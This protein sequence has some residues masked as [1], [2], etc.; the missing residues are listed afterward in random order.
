M[1]PETIPEQ[2][3]PEMARPIMKQLDAGATPESS[4][5]ISNTQIVDRNVVLVVHKLYNLPQN[6]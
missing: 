6:N 1:A 3:I 5:P 2:P 4:D